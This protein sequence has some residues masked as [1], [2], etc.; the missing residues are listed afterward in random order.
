MKQAL[1]CAYGSFVKFKADTMA[2]RRIEH[3][4]KMLEF[5]DKKGFEVQTKITDEAK[6]ELRKME[7]I[8]KV[9]EAE[10][11]RKLQDIEK[12]KKLRAEGKFEELDESTEG[13]SKGVTKQPAMEG[14][15]RRG[16]EATEV[17]TMTRSGFGQSKAAPAEDKK[18]DEGAL[19]R[20]EGGARPTFT[21]QAKKDEPETGA[22]MSRTMMSEKAP[23][24][25]EEDR[26]E[27]TAAGPWRSTTA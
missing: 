10:A 16:E 13:W 22:P 5:I 7:N 17:V 19:K 24:K 26:K 20:P 27:I 3:E 1:A 25:K 11:K 9:K 21:K 15:T 14:S 18:A 23:A 2:R 4:S 12:D 6:A 8:R